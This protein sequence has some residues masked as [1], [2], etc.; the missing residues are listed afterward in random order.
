MPVPGFVSIALDLD[1]DLQL[2]S[3]LISD[4]LYITMNLPGAHWAVPDPCYSHWTCLACLTWG[5]WDW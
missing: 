2:T 4:L 3:S 1:P 5:L